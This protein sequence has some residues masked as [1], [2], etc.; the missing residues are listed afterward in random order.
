[1]TSFN[2]QT[3]NTK[4]L[5]SEFIKQILNLYR[6]SFPVGFEGRNKNRK[7][8]EPKDRDS[9]R[10]LILEGEKVVSHAA[11]FS[12]NIE[13]AEENYILGCLG[14]IVTVV[15]YRNKSL[16]TK[17]VKIATDYI[18]AQDFDLG[19]LFCN[20]KIEDFY[21]RNN[22]E[23]LNNP[24]ITNEELDE[25]GHSPGLTMV[26]FLSEKAKINRSDFE[27]K[28]IFFGKSW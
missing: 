28:P 12:K 17:I 19:V 18:D 1:M 22:W 16:G 27:S 21:K 14:G 6:E 8:L 9:Q 23:K 25:K 5:P 13:H 2:Y 20:P 3:L 24:D 15:D 10:F 11:V 4:N 26:K 7:W